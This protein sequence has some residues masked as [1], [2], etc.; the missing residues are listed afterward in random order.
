MAIELPNN[1]ISRTLP[2]QV[3]F[4]SAKIAEIIKAINDFELV[5]KVIDIDSVSG[6][7]TDTQFGIAELSPSFILYSGKVF[8]KAYEDGTNI[9]FIEVGALA[10]GSTTLT[11]SV[12]RFRVVISTKA[13]QY[14]VVQL[15]E[16]YTKSQIDSLL[17]AGLA[18]KANLDGANFTGAITAPSIIENMS[19]YSATKETKAGI[20]TNVSYCGAVK[21]GNKLTLVAAFDAKRTGTVENNFF[22]PVEFTIPEGIYNKLYPFSGAYLDVK[23]ISFLKADDVLNTQV[24]VPSSCLK[25]TGNILRFRCFQI[26]SLLTQDVSYFARIEVTFLLSDSLI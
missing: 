13:Y 2:E 12:E 15:F 20:T 7:L 14:A 1:K 18:L 6:V 24:D 3:G 25:I 4:N 16:S 19:G 21:N 26:N 17:S 5:D 23:K 11:L 8:V 22:S 9:D 10:G